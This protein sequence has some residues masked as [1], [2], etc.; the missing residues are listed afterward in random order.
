M[1]ESSQGSAQSES[2]EVNVHNREKQLEK[3]LILLLYSYPVSKLIAYLFNL[4]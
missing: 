3:E 4:L 2:K 1:S